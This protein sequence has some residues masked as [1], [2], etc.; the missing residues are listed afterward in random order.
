M[1]TAEKALLDCL[2]LSTR[3][4]R[5]FAHLPELEPS[6]LDGKKFSR[7]LKAHSFSPAILAAIEKSAHN[8]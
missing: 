1:A 5:R 4:G 7:L 6:A 3:R 8:I 2:Y